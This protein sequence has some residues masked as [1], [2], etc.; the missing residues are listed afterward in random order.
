MIVTALAGDVSPD[1]STSRAP[2]CI[3]VTVKVDVSAEIPS[4]D[5]YWIF[6]IVNSLE[7]LVISNISANDVNSF[8]ILVAT[9]SAE[10]LFNSSTSIPVKP[11][12]AGSAPIPLTEN[13]I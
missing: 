10:S 4:E 13:Q 8:S 5:P 6:L 7:D 12:T 3:W 2:S 9:V 11:V 1:K